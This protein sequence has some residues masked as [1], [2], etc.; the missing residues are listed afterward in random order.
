LGGSLV[1]EIAACD[2]RRAVALRDINRILGVGYLD[3]WAAARRSRMASGD[4]IGI[5]MM[6]GR[7]MGSGH[8]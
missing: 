1:L 2:D 4:R 6:N 5:I 3:S 8:C 7:M